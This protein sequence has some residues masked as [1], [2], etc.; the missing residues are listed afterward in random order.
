MGLN[1][2]MEKKRAERKEE[3]GE[4]KKEKGDDKMVVEEI[5]REIER[6]RE[7]K[8]RI[9]RKEIKEDP[10]GKTKILIKERGIKEKEMGR[11]LPQRREA[12]KVEN[13]IKERK[14]AIRKREETMLWQTQL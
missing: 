4:G 2:E 9:G 3:R 12:K 5:Q 14:G 13:Q 7:E 11:N 6:I 1:L 8:I 10:K